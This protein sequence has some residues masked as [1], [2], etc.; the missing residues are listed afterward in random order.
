MK[1]NNSKQHLKIINKRIKGK[2]V[3]LPNKIKNYFV[4]D[5]LFIKRVTCLTVLLRGMGKWQRWQREG[6][7]ERVKQ[8]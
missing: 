4:I 6:E 2:T 7:R 8:R 3:N 5:D 1:K